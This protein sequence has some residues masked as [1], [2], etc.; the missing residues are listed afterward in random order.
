MSVAPQL[1][2]RAPP[3][4]VGPA[5][6]LSGTARAVAALGIFGALLAFDL[7]WVARSLPHRP[8]DDEW[9]YIYY[10]ENLLQG[11]FSPR[12]RVF[13]WNGPGYPLL[14][15]PFVKLGWLDGARYANTVWHAGAL[16][17][18]WLTASAR[19]PVRW[20]LGCV[21]VLGLY[22]P[23]YKFL[24][25]AQTEVLCFFLVAAWLEH[26]LRAPASLLHGLVAAAVLA[27]LCLTKV[28]FG[29]V[30]LPFLGLSLLRWLRRRSRGA[31]VVAAGGAGARAV[32]SLSGVHPRP[33]GSRVLLVERGAGLVLL[34]ELAAPR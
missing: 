30:L 20:A 2:D 11:Y 17:Y 26:S 25:L 18:A 34:A 10:A 9:R 31:S 22:A 4:L 27:L 14:L 1:R 7:Y 28:V 6:P 15:V 12:E 19:L 33:D 3:E 21:L 29:V 8:E 24:P 5:A 32:R 23:V 13:L 16:L